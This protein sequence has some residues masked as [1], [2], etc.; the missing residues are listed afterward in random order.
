MS[1]ELRYSCLH[2]VDHLRSSLAE[3][4]TFLDDGGRIMLLLSD[5]FKTTRSLFWLEIF[6]LTGSVNTARDIL[7]G[8]MQLQ[9]PVRVAR[10]PLFQVEA[11][12]SSRLSLVSVLLHLRCDPSSNSSSAQSPP[13]RRIYTSAS[14]GFPSKS[15]F[16]SLGER[17]TRALRF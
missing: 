11:E 7:V 9:S 12:Y 10:Y 8:L 5:F 16:G 6:S 2:W 4:S 13:A 1:T 17:I 15:S 3:S 14:H